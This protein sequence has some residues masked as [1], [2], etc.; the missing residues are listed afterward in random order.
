[1]HKSTAQVVDPSSLIS[2]V[3]RPHT[4]V[5]AEKKLS[6]A[7][8]NIVAQDNPDAPQQKCCQFASPQA[9]SARQYQFYR[10]PL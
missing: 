7:S 2:A 10:C 8:S 6:S 4:G 9:Q 1:M 5:N 3:K